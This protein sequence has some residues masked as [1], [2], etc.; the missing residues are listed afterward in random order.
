MS[1]STS[2]HD[3]PTDPTGGGNISNNI[4]LSAT[5]MPNTSNPAPTASL[6]LDQSTISQIV[7]GIQQASS[8]GATLLPSRDIPRT[9][10]TM[11]QDPQIQ[12]NYIPQV[13]Q[14]DYIR[15]YETP[16]EIL[17]NYNR[18]VKQ[19]DTLDDMYEEFQIP[20]LLAI[21]F[22]FFQLPI[23]KKKMF[24]FLPFLF[25]K[26]G[27]YNIQGYIFMSVLFGLFYYLLSKIMGQFNKF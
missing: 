20:L 24:T 21:L 17:N 8:T 9:T 14:K 10:E 16:Q 19:T 15:D 6:T 22:F 3:L 18:N 13:Q 25:F 23:F 5:E 26:D 27:N 2:I 1:D 7:S 4:S 11:M 12:A